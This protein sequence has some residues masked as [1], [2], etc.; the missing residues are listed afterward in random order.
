M[1]PKKAA[2]TQAPPD[3]QQ[4]VLQAVVLADS[5]N[6]RFQVLCVDRPRCLLPL[7]GVPLLAWTLEGL[8][9]SNVKE[10]V[11]FCGVHADAIKEWIG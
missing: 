11:V 3:E 10:V 1:P 7:L 5:F 2:P 6:H 9:L 4:E 8:Y